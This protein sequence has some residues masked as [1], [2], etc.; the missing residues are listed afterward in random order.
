MENR[1]L[2]TVILGSSGYLGRKVQQRFHALNLPTVLVDLNGHISCD[3]TN[4]EDLR[5]LNLPEKFNLIHLASILPGSKPARFLKES[6]R[7]MTDN[8]VSVLNPS[9]ML[10]VSSTAVYRRSTQNKDYPQIQPWEVY[11]EEKYWQEETLMKSFENL[12]IFRC[13]TL[14][15]E[16]RGGGISKLFKRGISGRALFLPNSGRVHHPFVDT[17]DVVNNLSDWAADFDN[18]LPTGVFDIVGKYP[19]RLNEIFAKYSKKKTKIYPLPRKI[20]ERVG[21]DTFPLFGISR[22]HLGALSYDLSNFEHTSEHY[23]TQDIDRVWARVTKSW[24][25]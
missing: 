25:E 10:F 19:R 4:L 3:L 14:I 17:N 16:D 11:G 2:P 5:K 12:T 13:G 21:S 1:P 24:L 9:K 8:I 20:T 23:I 22:W 15:D 18:S 7:R 6:S